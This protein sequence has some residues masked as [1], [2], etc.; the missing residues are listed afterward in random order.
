MGDIIDREEWARLERELEEHRR[1]YA[2]AEIGEA[3]VLAASLMEQGGHEEMQRWH[4]ARTKVLM[5]ADAE[6][7]R[8]E[9]DRG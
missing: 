5:L 7:K 8:R 2:A 3:A 4:E 6:L 1:L 9:A